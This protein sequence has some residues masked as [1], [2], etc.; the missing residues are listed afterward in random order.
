MT[1]PGSS[2]SSEPTPQAPARRGRRKTKAERRRE[3]R[4]MIIVGSVMAVI[5]LVAIVGG[6]AFTYWEQ[7]RNS[8]DPTTVTL[9]VTDSKGK[10]VTA[11]PYQAC[12]LGSTDCTEKSMTKISLPKDGKATIDVPSTVSDTQWSLLTIYEDNAKNDESVY[13][14]KDKKS[15]TIDGSKGGS[16]LKVAE[17]HAVLLG[18][19]SHDSDSSD[20]EDAYTMVWA[21]SPE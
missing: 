5:V 2:S 4:T 20:D 9:S 15:V 6:I 12:A 17:V 10:N 16:R 18:D 19:K 13:K 14:A 8:V 1:D 7:R 3:R 11:D 21:I